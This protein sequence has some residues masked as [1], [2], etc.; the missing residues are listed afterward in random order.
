MAVVIAGG[1][2]LPVFPNTITV[3]VADGR[4][5]F[6]KLSAIV[7]I[8]PPG[9]EVIEKISSITRIITKESDIT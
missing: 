6:Y 8:S 2:I 3:E 5:E 7:V 9:P 4:L 1:K